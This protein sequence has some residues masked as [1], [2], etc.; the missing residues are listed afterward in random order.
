MMVY[1]DGVCLDKAPFPGVYEV[2]AQEQHQFDHPER[3]R[4]IFQTAREALIQ[5]KET[6]NRREA[7][8][9]GATARLFRVGDIVKIQ[10]GHYKLP[11]YEMIG[12]KK[13]R[14]K[15]FGNY[16]R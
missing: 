10:L 12:A 14:Q 13:L 7:Q 11:R 9:P 16:I 3:M 8:L 1:A 15:Y 2:A 6:I 4:A 5:A